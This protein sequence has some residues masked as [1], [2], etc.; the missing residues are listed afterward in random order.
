MAP[1]LVLCLARSLGA[2][3][4]ARRRPPCCHRGPA[5]DEA[6]G[7]SPCPARSAAQTC[8]EHMHTGTQ[9]TTVLFR[10]KKISN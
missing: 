10:L 3:L 4:R 1:Y 7:S 6:A 8:Q 2:A 9:R 5:R